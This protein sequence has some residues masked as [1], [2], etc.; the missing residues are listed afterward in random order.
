[1]IRLDLQLFSGEKTEKATPKRRD[2]ARRKGQVARSQEIGQVLV[3]LAALFTIKAFAGMYLNEFVRLMQVDFSQGLMITI[4]Q[5]SFTPYMLQMMLLIAKL[6]LPVMGV[7][8]VVGVAVSYFQVGTLFTLK[9]LM[10]DL[11]K[12]DPI[13]GMK[14]LFSLKSVVES[15]KSMIKILIIGFV[16]YSELSKDWELVS[17]LGNMDILTIVRVMGDLTYGIFWK[18]GLAML[19]LALFDLWYQRFDYEKSLRMSKQE[20]KDEHKQVEGNPEVKGKIKEKQRAMALRRMMA[21]VPK[22]DVV[23]TNPTHFA[24][25]IQYDPEK[26]E[27]PIVLAKGLD[28]TAQRIKKI[29]REANVVLVENKPLART[30][31]ATVEIGQSIPSDLFQAVAEVLA[32]V[33][34][35]KGKA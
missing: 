11:K 7:S 30:L 19:G 15:A 26:M 9:P 24:V 14:R 17:Q 23:I 28:E 18:S 31:Y 8:L 25:A 29:A 34:R 5:Q 2:D 32:Y 10:P 3:L 4:D 20:I 21:D 13:A 16:V 12:L 35:L 27:A 6:V 33:Y 1:V 22:A